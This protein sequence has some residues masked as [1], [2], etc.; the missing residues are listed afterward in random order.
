MAWAR[1]VA[2]AVEFI[3]SNVLSEA[4]AGYKQ[5]DI[6]SIIDVVPAADEV[7]EAIGSH[8]TAPA[9]ATGFTPA[10]TYGVP[11]TWKASGKLDPKTGLLLL[12]SST[13]KYSLRLSAQCM[14]DIVAALKRIFT[15]VD[16]EF[17][18]AA[19]ASGGKDVLS[20]KWS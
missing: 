14:P 7:L 20:I 5:Q 9:P 10:S 16:I 19:P 17:V 12:V 8:K 11:E 15:D 1:H 18:R 2:G 6:S 13:G 4:L 3:K